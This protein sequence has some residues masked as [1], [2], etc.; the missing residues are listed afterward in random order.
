MGVRYCIRDRHVRKNKQQGRVETVPCGARSHS[1]VMARAYRHQGEP[2]RKRQ[3]FLLGHG[4][5]VNVP[6]VRGRL[7][8]GLLPLLQC[9]RDEDSA[10]LGLS[11]RKRTSRQQ[12]IPCELLR[13]ARASA[14]GTGST[15]TAMVELKQGLMYRSHQGDK[16]C[17]QT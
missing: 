17:K 5:D 14:P 2:L 6:G 9:T 16:K 8:P 1:C 3:L 10:R 4:T 15:T 12:G 11:E 7:L 13:S